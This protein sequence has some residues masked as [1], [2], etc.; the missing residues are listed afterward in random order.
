MILQVI[1]AMVAGWIN[2]HQ[3]QV[4]A[5][6]QEENRVLKSKL[7]GGRLRLSDTERRRLA[8]LAHPLG[9]KRLKHLA[10]LATPD[11]LMRWYKRLIANQYDGSKTRKELGR[12]RICEEI[13]QLVMRM[14]EENPPWGYRRIQGA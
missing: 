3:Q 9:C 8:K 5:Y 11:T 1:M 6:L 12:P 4:I 10:T 13:E 7:P 14:A 2:R